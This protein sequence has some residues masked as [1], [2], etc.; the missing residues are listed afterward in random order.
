MNNWTICKI[1]MNAYMGY[2][3]SF[4]ISEILENL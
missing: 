4:K 2:I 3:K 1:S